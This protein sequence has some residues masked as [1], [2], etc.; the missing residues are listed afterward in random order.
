MKNVLTIPAGIAGPSPWS[1]HPHSIHKQGL[2]ALKRA[3][4]NFD[5]EGF[6]I[7]SLCGSRKHIKCCVVAKTVK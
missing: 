7:L 4:H 2:P 6:S 5:T 3:D 1:G